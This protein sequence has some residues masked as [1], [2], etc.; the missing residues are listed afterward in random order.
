MPF[1]TMQ[2]AHR[3]PNLTSQACPHRLLPC[4]HRRSAHT[5]EAFGQLR[6]LVL[7][8]IPPGSRGAVPDLSPARHLR[9]TFLQARYHGN[10]DTGWDKPRHRRLPT[11]HPR[12]LCCPQRPP[13]RRRTLSRPLGRPRRRNSFLYVPATTAPRRCAGRRRLWSRGQGC[14][15]GLPA[16]E[17]RR[18]QLR[19]A[20]QE[21]ARGCFSGLRRDHKAAAPG[22]GG[23]TA[24]LFRSR[25]SMFLRHG[26]WYRDRG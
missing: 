13:T 11:W 7:D 20:S 2:E 21:A 16:E 18:R 12:A 4:T 26:L 9:P 1:P 19:R 24:V 5:A 25:K 15:G 23:A 6:G 8:G 10:G 17:P 3:F 22:R 14:R